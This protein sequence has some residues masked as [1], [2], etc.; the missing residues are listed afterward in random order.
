MRERLSDLDIYRR[1]HA[2]AV[3]FEDMA[4]R[5]WGPDGATALRA[6]AERTRILASGLYHASLKVEP[7]D[8]VEPPTFP[9]QG[10]CSTD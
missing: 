7:G 10:G 9:L 3:E 4:K 1:L 6:E 2:L 5:A 8:G